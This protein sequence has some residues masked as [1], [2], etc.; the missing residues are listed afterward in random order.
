MRLGKNALN[1]SLDVDNL[2]DANT[3]ERV[4]DRMNRGSIFVSDDTLLSGTFDYTNQY[5]PDARFLMAR[6]FTAPR[7]A[8]LRI[9]FTF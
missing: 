8:R 9:R 1:F 5:V 2:F 3:A 7:S 6:E 4:Y